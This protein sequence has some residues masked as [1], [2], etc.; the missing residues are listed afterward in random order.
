MLLQKYFCCQ[1]FTIQ[2]CNPLLI[3]CKWNLLTINQF[4]KLI[5]KLIF[6]NSLQ[7]ILTHLICAHEKL[8]DFNSKDAILEVYSI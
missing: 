5:I 2:E 3:C 7:I 8:T 6:L 4:L 1:A